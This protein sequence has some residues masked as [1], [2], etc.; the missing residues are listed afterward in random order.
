MPLLNHSDKSAPC[1]CLKRGSQASLASLASLASRGALWSCRLFLY[2]VDH[3][4]TA[5]QTHSL[6]DTRPHRHTASQTHGLTGALVPS[7]PPP[8]FAL[9]PPPPPA[10][11]Q[12]QRRSRRL[13]LLSPFSRPTSL[14]WR[15][16]FRVSPRRRD[17]AHSHCRRQ[18]SAGFTVRTTTVS[19]TPAL[20]RLLCVRHT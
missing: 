15:P 19:G 5:S 18:R 10:R 7:P 2:I 11:A 13:S 8:W 17:G 9:P 14:H 16:V 12:Q 3:R 1:N 6:T 20:I 4:H